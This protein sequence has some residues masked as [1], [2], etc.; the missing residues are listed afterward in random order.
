MA[1]PNFPIDKSYLIAAWLAS[2]FWGAFTV[3]FAFWLATTITRPQTRSWLPIGAVIFMYGLATAH[4]SC[5]L[6]RIIQAFIVHINDEGGAILY[7]A[8]IGQPLNRSK[9]MIYVTM[10]VLADTI[11]VWRCFMVWNKNYY[12]IAVPS[13][14]ALATAIS[15]YGAIARYYTPNPYTPTSVQWAEGMLTVSM[16]TNII[17]TLLTAGKIWKVAHGLGAMSFGPSQR[18]YHYVILLIVES[19]V[20]MAASKTLEFILFMLAPNDGLDGLNA[21]YI[22]MDC[23]PQIMGICPTFIMLAVNRG[24][25]SSGSQAYVTSGS[26][27]QSPG[28]GKH[29]VNTIAFATGSAEGVKTDDASDNQG[30]YALQTMKEGD[31]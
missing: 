27:K 13:I 31:N 6:A 16:A 17:V 14:M 21:L 10:I 5:V 4:I 22:V 25:T 3:I 23:M 19:G 1:L 26:M 8:D 7:L 12:V 29:V 30:A 15:G 11:L 9:D 28:G 24:F 20:V 2:A 18:R